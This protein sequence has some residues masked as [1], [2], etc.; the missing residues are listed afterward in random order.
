MGLFNFFSSK[1]AESVV[2]V[3]PT[4]TDL[5]TLEHRVENEELKKAGLWNRF[6]GRLRKSTAERDL[7]NL[8]VNSDALYTNVKTSAPAV[9]PEGTFNP[10]TAEQLADEE[11]LRQNKAKIQ[12]WTEGRSEQE[13]EE[14]IKIEDKKS[15]A[16]MY[17]VKSY[18]VDGAEDEKS[19]T[20]A[21][22]VETANNR[23]LISQGLRERL[24]Q[25]KLKS[26]EASKKLLSQGCNV[27]DK[28]NALDKNQKLGL[29][30]LMAWAGIA[31]GGASLLLSRTF[32][33]SSAIKKM[34]DKET[35]KI[36]KGVVRELD[37]KEKRI[38]L[39]KAAAVGAAIG[40]A[41]QGIFD[42]LS[43]IN[44]VAGDS[45]A[46]IISPE[47]VNNVADTVAQVE[48]PKETV[49][50]IKNVMDGAD[51]I[52]VASIAPEAPSAD[53]SQM[54]DGETLINEYIVQK[55]D[56]LEK[57][58]MERAFEDNS[59]SKEVKLAEIYNMFASD[60]GKAILAESGIT[61]INNIQAG[62]KIDLQK[63]SDLLN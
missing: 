32:T 16:G 62:Q 50:E 35:E 6:V 21:E 18:K 43:S 12:Q 1:Q 34:I 40:I 10:K 26:A 5:S 47:E 23:E 60:A 8:G 3:E 48:P 36:K 31:T 57:V 58:L 24:A 30:A 51:N 14:A 27:M 55:G 63:F 33:A 19:G 2:R 37:T 25:M 38:V 22:R 13:I 56:S 49:T 20:R 11:L 15:I 44:D 28:Y 29:G 52:S 46:N 7:N 42:L 53:I 9:K 45:I 41:G 4:V 39:L 54:V 61:D 59:F 17:D